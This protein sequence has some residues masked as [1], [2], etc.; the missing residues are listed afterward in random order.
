MHV[1]PSR[2]AARGAVFP[3]CN[4]CNPHGGGRRNFF[5][6]N[7]N[8]ALIRAQVRG[9][10]T[11]RP[12]APVRRRQQQHG[13]TMS[14]LELGYKHAGIDDGWQEC[15]SYTVE[16]TGAPA[17]HSALGIPNVN[18]T[19]FP[20]LRDL[21]AYATA[22][23]VDLGWYIN[24]CICHESASH[25]HN[26]SWTQRTYLGDVQQLTHSNFKGVK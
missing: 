24:N 23:G 15:N 21:N 5:K 18:Y 4:R 6:G 11:R 8:D 12:V 22:R 20:D 2:E 25:I 26:E 1:S 19:R 14:L 16:P 3:G 7:I 17:F 10:L 13:A 9:L